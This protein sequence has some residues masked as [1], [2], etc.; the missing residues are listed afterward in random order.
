MPSLLKRIEDRRA[1]VGIIG[2]GYVGLPLAQTFCASGF[3]LVGFD[4]DQAKVKAL[5]AA[6]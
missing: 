5:T 4:I 2:M 1:V 3:R 6:V